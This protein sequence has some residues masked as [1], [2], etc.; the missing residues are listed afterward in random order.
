MTDATKRA[1]R[2]FGNRLGNCAYD[3]EFL[4]DVRNHNSSGGKK[5]NDVYS[6]P[7]VPSTIAKLQMPLAANFNDNKPSN[8]LPPNY[9]PTWQHPKALMENPQQNVSITTNLKKPVVIDSSSS[10]IG[11]GNILLAE[12]RT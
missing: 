9:T 7:Q 10:T 5:K 1:L 8:A 3:K 2:I 12:E 11:Y 6:K 4:Q